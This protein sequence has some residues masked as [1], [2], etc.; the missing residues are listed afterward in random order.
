MKPSVI[1][2]ALDTVGVLY[3]VIYYDKNLNTSRTT[4][5]LTMSW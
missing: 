2:L 5:L 4:M 1:M 3:Q